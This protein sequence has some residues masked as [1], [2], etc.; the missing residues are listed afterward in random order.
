MSTY[1]L[2]YDALALIR[3]AVEASSPE[4][5][6]RLWRLNQV[7]AA[8][9]VRIEVPSCSDLYVCDNRGHLLDRFQIDEGNLTEELS[10]MMLEESGYGLVRKTEEPHVREEG[11]FELYRTLDRLF[12]IAPGRREQL[13]PR[14]ISRMKPGKRETCCSGVWKRLSAWL[15]GRGG[16]N[17]C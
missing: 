5:A 4:E 2:E 8:R 17:R 15:W 14:L 9:D 6:V 11:S 3:V 10:P 16:G 7:G 13:V 1:V 12:G